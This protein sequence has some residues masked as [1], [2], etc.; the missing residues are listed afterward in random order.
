MTWLLARLQRPA[1]AGRRV[2]LRLS[3][4]ASAGGPVALW[5]E[6]HAAV[7]FDEHGVAEV[8]LGLHEP[9]PA[10]VL[11]DRPR[12]LAAATADGAPAGPR[13]PLDTRPLA[14]DAQLQRLRTDRS[15]PP[16]GLAAVADAVGALRDHV[17]ALAGAEGD[18]GAAQDALAEGL[19]AL[20][21]RVDALA[22]QHDGLADGL[23]DVAGP[24]GELHDHEQRLGRLEARAPGL[25][26]GAAAPRRAAPPVRTVPASALLSPPAE[27]PMSAELPPSPWFDV[28]K[29][30]FLDG[31]AS[32]FVLHGLVHDVHP[33]EGEDGLR[34]GPLADAV[35]ARL[36]ASRDLVLRHDS[37][38][39]LRPHGARA[40][41]HLEARPVAPGLQPALA[42]IGRQLAD[43]RQST[44]VVIDH[45]DL[46]FP[47]APPA[48]PDERLARSALRHWADD[49]SLR[50]SNN[51]LFLIVAEPALLPAELLAHPR[52]ATVEVGPH[53]GPALRA[54]LRSAHGVD[55][56]LAD[57]AVLDGP[58]LARV[59]AL[60]R[61]AR[62][63]GEPTP[64]DWAAA[65]SPAGL[66]STAT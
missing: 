13:R 64:D 34:W 21:A 56:P 4:H 53:R 27:V 8:V 37:F 3:L 28:V 20:A 23:A 10:A 54:F 26:Q 17:D 36:H 39:G 12:W 9:L 33:H 59:G 11:S 32:I 65:L 6:D 55:V 60:S 43:R 63:A 40:R 47:A 46:L 7:E 61:V 57:A 58:L 50:E 49:P 31:A 48:L 44:A 15:A 41:R 29:D 22:A 51:I 52:V 42:R 35:C 45:A 62:A 14:R 25:Q 18:R 24:G 66:L 16:P 38:H 2:A 19:A 30:A 1:L 5:A